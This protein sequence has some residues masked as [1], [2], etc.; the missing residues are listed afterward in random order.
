MCS[1]CDVDYDEGLAEDIISESLKLFA[2]QNK[3]NL[4]VCVLPKDN[5][6]TVYL[7]SN[8]TLMTAGKAKIKYCPMCGRKLTNGGN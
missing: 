1:Y 7:S 3:T 8:D 4:Y 5:E 2:L 6:L